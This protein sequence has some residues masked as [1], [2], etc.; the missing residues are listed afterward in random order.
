MAVS[1]DLSEMSKLDRIISRGKPMR[2]GQLL[3]T[4]GENFISVFALKTGSVKTYTTSAEG[5][6]QITGFY[7][8]GDLIG[9]NGI[10]SGTCPDSI[11]ALE[12][13]TACKIEFEQL[14]Q[15]SVDLPK[16]RRQILK[17]MSK[18]IC[19][20]QNMLQLLANKNSDERVA[21]F[22]LR[23]SNR[24]KARGFS[25]SRFRLPMSRNEIA[26]YL[27]LTVETVSRVFTRMQKNGFILVNNKEI[28]II[29]PK[30]LLKLANNTD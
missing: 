22:L 6:E 16:L 7:F 15:L 8:P 11:Q 18:D 20:E 28:Q 10:H 3:S 17:T 30:A 27:G 25:E 14:D 12:T 1:L 23:L 21:T 13:T 24:F 26:N 5:D 2:K 29:E 9:L 19:N 4:Q